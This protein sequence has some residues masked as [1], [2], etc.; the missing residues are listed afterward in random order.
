MAFTFEALVGLLKMD[1]SAWKGGLDSGTKD[2]KKFADTSEK[3]VKQLS[4]SM[5]KAFS[6]IKSMIANVFVAGGITAFARN[7]IGEWTQA[8]QANVRLKVAI[9]ATG[10]AAMVSRDEM[11]ALAE[12]IH[13]TTTYE[14]DAAIAGMAMLTTMKEIKG[15][16]F[17][18]VT[19]AAAD[20]AAATGGDL[21][22]AMEKLGRA[23]AD[24]ETGMMR[25]RREGIF[26]TDAQQAMIKKMSEAGQVAKAQ[27][28]ILDEL[29]SR[30]GGTAAEI[31]NTMGGALDEFKKKMNDVAEGMGKQL[32]PSLRDLATGSE[33]YVNAIGSIFGRIADGWSLG[34]AMLNDEH[35]K[36]D[37]IVKRIEARNKEAEAQWAERSGDI[38]KA[39]QLREEAAKLSADSESDMERAK[40]I[41]DPSRVAA[42]R[43]AAAEKAKADADKKRKAELDYERGVSQFGR[44]PEAAA[45]GTSAGTSGTSGSAGSPSGGKSAAASDPFAGVAD[46]HHERNIDAQKH[47]GFLK[48]ATPDEARAFVAGMKKQIDDAIANGGLRLTDTGEGD[49]LGFRQIIDTYEAKAKLMEGFNAEAWATMRSDALEA[50]QMA[51]ESSGAMRDFYLSQAESALQA[52]DE[53]FEAVERRAEEA[54]KLAKEAADDAKREA[55]KRAAEAKREAER[56]AEEAKQVQ[57]KADKENAE[58]DKAAQ[59]KQFAER[60]DFMFDP[61][62]NQEINERMAEMRK[63]ANASI[64]MMDS[65]EQKAAFKAFRDQ[66]EAAM[67]AVRDSTGETRKANIEQLNSLEE[68]WAKAFEA[69]RSGSKKTAE[70]LVADAKKQ[71][72]ALKEAA[73]KTTKAASGGKQ[74]AFPD[75]MGELFSMG[76]QMSNAISGAF[77]G[78]GGG[79]MSFADALAQTKDPLERIDMQIGSIKASMEGMSIN[80]G[81]FGSNL[82]TVADFTGQIAALERERARIVGE[83]AAERAEADRLHEETYQREQRAKAEQ[84]RDRR[85]EQGLDMEGAVAVGKVP[86][87]VL[88]IHGVNDVRQAVDNFEKELVRR[89]INKSGKKTLS[90]R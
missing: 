11:Q 31:K 65:P 37:A 13:K 61:K 42:R 18:Q 51:A 59:Q 88:N 25:L 26:F 69:M 12:Q 17:K 15:D 27:Q 38:A 84:E 63:Q 57:K 79:M 53:M 66:M 21:V 34:L 50:Y 77:A 89:G 4:D 72:D 22:G 60:N 47:A 33:P 8:E 74:A 36:A 85:R 54:K 67:K 2:L 46:A 19:I 71:G 45:T 29:K 48:T 62:N 82:T 68:A 43:K 10:G 78:V 64:Q 86:P 73:E 87:V 40:D 90:A 32:A 1:S 39:K 80:A 24:P 81:N 23:L 16:I 70:Q 83:Q 35:T 3:E 14:D 55:E 49:V 20:M 75:M 5:G 6:G 76:Q 44:T 41:A 30:Y 52:S 7:A 58:R 56:R 28:I 9:R